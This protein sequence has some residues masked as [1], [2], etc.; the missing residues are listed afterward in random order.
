MLFLESIWNLIMAS[1][2]PFSSIPN[3]TI[4]IFLIATFLSLITNLA[5]RFLI[6]IEKMK[7]MSKE[8]KA[9]RDEFD[10]AR[11]T[12][13]KQLMDKVMKKQKAIMQLQA[14]MMA[15]QM[16]VG[17]MFFIPFSIIYFLLNSFY[18]NTPVALSPFNLPMLIETEIPF[19]KWYIICSFATSL[20]LR[21]LIGVALEGY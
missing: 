6:D 2:K 11:K 12:G 17:F 5:N 18:G 21:H 13:N 14:K 4:L 9:W 3:S 16:K 15:D 10:K 1:L 8:V 20:P 19:W 7:S